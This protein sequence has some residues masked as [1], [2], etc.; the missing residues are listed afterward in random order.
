MNLEH[1]S[2]PL[3]MKTLEDAMKTIIN[4][5]PLISP[6][7]IQVCH[8]FSFSWLSELALSQTPI[9]MKALKAFVKIK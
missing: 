3:V 2:Y 1:T 9:F 4:R 7:A 6:E 8:V 5:A